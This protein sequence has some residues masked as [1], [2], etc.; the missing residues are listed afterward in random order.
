MKIKTKKGTVVRCRGVM[1]PPTK[2][3]RN[4]KKEAGRKACRRGAT[5]RRVRDELGR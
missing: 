1:P 5:R 2:R 4:R 3:F